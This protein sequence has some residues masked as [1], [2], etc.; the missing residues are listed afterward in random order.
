MHTKT[1]SSIV[2]YSQ[3]L[4]DSL[5]SLIKNTN[6]EKDIIVPNISNIDNKIQ[7][8]FLKR[9]IS[10]YNSIQETLNVQKHQLGKNCFVKVERINNNNIYF[11]QMFCD[12]L[13]KSRNIN[14]IHL[15]NCMIDIRNFCVNIKKKEDKNVEIHAPKFGTGI[16]GGRWSTITDLIE[17]CWSGI[18]TFIYKDN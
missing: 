2:Y 4:L 13:S 6:T 12:K 3:D 5:V 10:K 15:V 1:Q 16:S 8:N 17:D 18:P 11:C 7:N 9:S 14:Y